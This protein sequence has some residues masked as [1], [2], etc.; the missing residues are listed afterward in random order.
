MLSQLGKGLH[1]SLIK[2]F[3]LGESWGLRSVQK[4]AQDYSESFISL[5]PVSFD[6]ETGPPSGGL[7]P[8]T[9]WRPLMWE[10]KAFQHTQNRLTS[11]SLQFFSG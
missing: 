1:R 7:L 9:P 2:S 6:E 4:L 8:S 3:L 11:Y 10:I 5:P